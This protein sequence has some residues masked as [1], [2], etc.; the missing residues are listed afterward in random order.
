[1]LIL[2]QGKINFSVCQNLPFFNFQVFVNFITKQL[3]SI[4]EAHLNNVHILIP[5]I[6]RF[7]VL[8]SYEK[9]H[10]RYKFNIFYTCK[11]VMLVS[12][13]SSFF[14]PLENLILGTIYNDCD[15][16]KHTVLLKST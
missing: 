13:D 3:Q 15:H 5:D 14:L 11:F 4:E 2:K 16:E 8:L 1:M 9:H 12:S 10:S 7:L 6:F